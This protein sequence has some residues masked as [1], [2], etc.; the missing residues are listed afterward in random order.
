MASENEG[1]NGPTEQTASRRRFLQQATGIAGLAAVNASPAD[2]TVGSQQAALLPTIKLGQHQITRLIVGGNPI[3]GHSHFNRLLS[4]H[5][6]EWHTPE[7]VLALLKRCEQAGINC[8][9]NSYADRTLQDLE[10]YREA[11]GKMNWLCLGKPDWDQH[12]ERIADA[13]KRK[14]IGIAPHGALAERLHRAGKLD[15]L[16]GLLKRI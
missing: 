13:A 15:V 3:Y 8:W 6:T 5:L 7:H 11:G 10:R 2:A 1:A 14:P 12:P 16:T 9:Q 4:Q